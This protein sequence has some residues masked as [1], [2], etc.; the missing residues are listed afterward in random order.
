VSHVTA[1]AFTTPLVPLSIV[2]VVGCLSLVVLDPILDIPLL[3]PRIEGSFLTANLVVS[4][5]S[6][7]ISSAALLGGAYRSR[8]DNN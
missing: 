2:I 7:V 4:A 1:T 3:E 6:L 8:A 5:M